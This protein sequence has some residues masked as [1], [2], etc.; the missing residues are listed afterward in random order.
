MTPGLQQPNGLLNLSCNYLTHVT[1]MNKQKWLVVTLALPDRSFWAIGAVA[2]ATDESET[3]E[4]LR[5]AA[6]AI[7]VDPEP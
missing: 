5:I 3:Y 4:L 6:K 2:E 1:V 7:V